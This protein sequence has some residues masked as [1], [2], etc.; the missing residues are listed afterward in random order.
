MIEPLPNCRSIWASALDRATAFSS[1]M[2]LRSADCCRC[3]IR[4]YRAVVPDAWQRA[5]RRS[6]VDPTLLRA[7]KG[8]SLPIP[9]EAGSIEP[10]F[11]TPYSKVFTYLSRSP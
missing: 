1:A 11:D 9:F 7:G 6:P 5:N 4:R 8:A 2:M 10:V 3:R